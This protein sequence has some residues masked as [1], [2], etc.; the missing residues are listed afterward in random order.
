MRP[1][2]VQN[3]CAFD[4]FFLNLFS[5]NKLLGRYKRELSLKKSNKNRALI[6]IKVWSFSKLYLQQ[7]ILVASLMSDSLSLDRIFVNLRKTYLLTTRIPCRGKLLRQLD[8]DTAFFH[9][10]MNVSPHTLYICFLPH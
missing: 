4:L 5:A 6:L 2:K 3:N 7:K 9:W 10:P 8:A 1:H